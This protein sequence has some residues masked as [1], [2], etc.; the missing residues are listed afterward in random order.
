MFPFGPPLVQQWDGG[1]TDNPFVDRTRR[2]QGIALEQKVDIH[3]LASTI[4]V[5]LAMAPVLKLAAVFRIVTPPACS[6]T[7][8]IR[9][10][11]QIR[12]T[13]AYLT[14]RLRLLNLTALLVTLA[15]P[16]HTPACKGSSTGG[17]RMICQIRM[18]SA[19]LSDRLRLLN[20]TALR[21]RHLL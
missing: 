13:S 7:G 20:L 14:D 3:S 2:L 12:M 6:S 21:P 10:V 4:L 9:M 17:I 1:R 8:G 16:G 15:M 5:T 18:A 11:C 19:Y